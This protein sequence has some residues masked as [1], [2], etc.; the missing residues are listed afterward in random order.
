MGLDGKTD[1]CEEI[2]RPV[3]DYEDKYEVS[4]LGRVR[5]IN[6]GHIIKG[7]PTKDGYIRIKLYR[8]KKYESRMAHRMVA[9]A[10]IPLPDY[11]N[12]YEVDHKDD[13]VQNNVVENL[14]W[15]THAENLEKSFK[16]GHQTK[17][18]KPIAQ[19][20]LDWNLIAV[21]EGKN[22]AFRKTGI[23]HT[24]ECAIGYRNYKTAGG[25]NWRYVEDLEGE[26]LDGIGQCY[27]CA[28]H[29]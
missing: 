14:Q 22:D 21:Y 15:L 27:L 17:P 1:I 25:Y 16:R 23:R 24:G 12:E 18:K 7:D 2:W 19:F 13:D 28:S 9:D 8:N 26:L 5:N 29:T 20:D 11:E 3:K 10:F 4:N 6:T